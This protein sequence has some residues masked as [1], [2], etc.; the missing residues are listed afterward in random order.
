MTTSILP[1]P[2]AHDAGAFSGFEPKESSNASRR[3]IGT[4]EFRYVEEVLASDFRGSAKPRM[5]EKLEKIFCEKFGVAY[6][7]SCNS[8]T[9]TLHSALCAGGVASGDE[10][11]VPPLTMASTALAVLHQG[12]IPVFADIDPETWTLDPNAMRRLLSPRTKAI[13]PVAIYGLA[14][15]MD[16]IMEIAAERQLTV[17]EDVAQCFLGRYRG[18]L[19]GA[20][21]H[22][23]SFSF[24]SSKHMTCGEGGMV[25]CNRHDLAERVR[26]H[27]SLGY[28][29]LAAGPG[30]SKIRKE[31]LLDPNYARH[32]ALGWNYR[33]PELCAAVALGQAV[34]LEEFVQKRMAAAKCY[35]D[36][37]AGCDWL[38][39]QKVPEDRVHSYWAFVV[40]LDAAS[41]GVDW[42]TFRKKYQELGGDRVYAAWRLNYLEPFF[43]ELQKKPQGSLAHLSGQL[44]ERQRW[45][46][47]LCPHAEAVQPWL[48]QFKT[49]Y[50]DLEL[51]AQKADALRQTIRHFEKFK[52]R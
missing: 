47:G 6:A 41:I 42:Q 20:I 19:A 32:V 1:V 50:L 5:V 39:P 23:G 3:R 24:Q 25:I 31:D 38:I 16:D 35:L 49:N 51:A 10:V 2:L 12:A 4:D 44:G 28:A 21:G 29:G 17:I 15:D 36:A 43:Q 8:G 22:M 48:L 52:R 27:S 40:R 37:M 46:G 7:I 11:I 45:D 18:R 30:C 26:R 9:S 34:R 33:M 14:P 13:I